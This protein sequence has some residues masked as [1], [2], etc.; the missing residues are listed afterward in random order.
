MI[1]LL[2][3]LY[4]SITQYPSSVG[5]GNPCRHGL[6]WLECIIVDWETYAVAYMLAYSNSQEQ[7][8]LA[9]GSMLIFLPLSMGA[10]ITSWKTM[11]EDM[12]IHRY[13][14][15]TTLFGYPCL[16]AWMD[17]HRGTP[18]SLTKSSYPCSMDICTD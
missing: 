9:R 12:V 17:V 4:S 18:I 2:I 13:P 15:S 6:P 16:T 5:H 7:S 8:T 10:R 1:L 14:C 3:D 11:P